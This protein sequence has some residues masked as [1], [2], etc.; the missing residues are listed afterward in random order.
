MKIDRLYTLL[1]CS[2]LEDLRLQRDAEECEELLS[3]W[4]ALWHPGLIAAAGTVPDWHPADQP[5]LETTGSL[6]AL[7]ECCEGLLPDGWTAEA[8]ASGALL[9][10]KFKHRPEIVQAALKGMDCEA[11]KVD[12]DLAADFHALGYCR[13]VV[14]VL[15]RKFRY[16][17]NFDQTA[18]NDAVLAAAKA[19][20]EGD[21]AEARQALQSAFDRLHEAREYF[22]P[23]EARLIDFTLAAST[24]LGQSLQRELTD[25]TPRNLLISAAVLQ[26][27]AVSEPD[28]LA[29]LKNA[30]ETNSAT[31]VGGEFIEAPLP[32]LPP[33]AI[34]FHLQ[35]GL[36]IYKRILDRRPVIFG[37]R[38]F[39][40]A[41]ALPQILAKNGF[42]AAAHFTLDDGQ[43]PTDN[44]SFV[45]WE[46]FD[47]TT[48]DA[49]TKIPLV[50]DKADAFFRLPE[51]LANAFELDQPAAV[52]FAHWPGR[53]CTW[54]GDLCRINSYSRV[55]GFFCTLDE[56]FQQ[57]G[58]SGRRVKYGAD[59]YRSPYLVQGVSANLPDAIS[60]WVDY[61]RRRSTW[62]AA[63][64]LYTIAALTPKKEPACGVRLKKEP[65]CGPTLKKETA[66]G[67]T[68][69]K[70]PAC[71]PTL[72]KEPARGP[73]L[74][75]ESPCGFAADLQKIPTLIED[76]LN[77]L[78]SPFGR[79]AGGEGIN[80]L[81]LDQLLRQTLDSAVQCFAES[82][83]GA[84]EKPLAVLRCAGY[85]LANPCSFSRRMAADLPRLETPPDLEAPIKEAEKNK[86][87]VDLPGMGFAWIGPGEEKR[88]LPRSVR[89]I[90]R[91]FGK[92]HKAALPL[93]QDN[94]LRNEFFEAVVD[95]RT[96]AIRAINDYRG[97]H[98][99][100]AQQIALR[101]PRAGDRD[102]ASEGR[103]SIMSADE[104]RVTSSGPVFGEIVSSGKITD[105]DGCRLAGFKQ[106]VRAWSG[107]RVLELEIELDVDRHP[108][109]DPW[110]SYYACRFA[111]NDETCT[112]FRGVNSTT[113][114]TESRHLESPYFID[115]R[116]DRAR[117][118]ILCGGLP[119]HRRIGFR[120]L[121]TLLIVQGES[122]RRFRL[123]IGIDLPNAMTAA[124]GFLSPKTVYFPAASPPMKHGWLFHLDHRNVI[125]ANW[126]PLFASPLPLGEGQGEGEMAMDESRVQGPEF[127]V[128]NSGD[129]GQWAVDNGKS[130]SPAA[131]GHYAEQSRG[132][133]PPASGLRPV[134]GFRVR[135]LETEG[136]HAR[137]GLRCFR[138]IVWARVI[139]CDN[140]TSGI[141]SIEDDRIILPVEPYKM[142]D[143]EA[144]FT[145][146]DAIN[147]QEL[148]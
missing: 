88:S 63:Q 128:Q 101:L 97:R 64:T 36:E 52:V 98:P 119:Y 34:E 28:T 85:L 42:T 77:V 16:M 114:P 79:G 126:E 2:G 51:I 14:E 24:T 100:L 19:A 40:L 62:E 148:P 61:Y 130:G 91:M 22:F 33:E 12:P 39:G 82:L 27:M 72:K 54:Y 144:F 113:Q 6:F 57:T 1:P 43:F 66:C 96:G 41:P 139:N 140:P 110:N 8:E 23:A 44:Q 107:S 99:R 135:L 65:A 120:K 37:R 123:G 80:N 50:A 124:L 92:K 3:A 31:I 67:P 109:S 58:Q 115:V 127:R 143:I 103:Y 69:K 26:N 141:L 81:E 112:L 7:P 5:P 117:T 125:A 35:R 94:V 20:V 122:A 11:A 118:T 102:Q 133:H 17:G 76:S 47:G 30:L 38:R 137:L 146:H 95:Q 138:S 136:R 32:L 49:L 48:I 104:I 59:Q 147:R 87:V 18:C 93:A 10:R 74:K 4:T 105:G 21:F 106:T 83:A 90:S 75:K 60:H 25:G 78:P 29:A 89:K 56:F 46:G 132:E 108:E 9:L 71:G 55:L 53:V 131:T 68:L 129:S 45:Q 134:V 13:F 70:E 142:I 15:T 86:A 73:T 116:A 111:W 84:P 145:E 121:D